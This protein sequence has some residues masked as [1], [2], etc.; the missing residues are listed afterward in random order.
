MNKEL[1]LKVA[2]AIEQHPT[3]YNQGSYGWGWLDLEGGC[4]S[5]CCVVGWAF[6]LSGFKRQSYPE[7][8]SFGHRDGDIY[9]R[10]SAALGIEVPNEEIVAGTWPS[11]WLTRAGLELRGILG[12]F[13]PRSDEAAI[14]LRAMVQGGGFWT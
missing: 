5:A 14:I 11:G 6:V 10:G 8:Y 4:G 3:L 13:S 7:S 1:M 2:D 12:A 9:R